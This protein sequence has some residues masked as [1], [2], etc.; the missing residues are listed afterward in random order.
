M[1]LPFVGEAI[2]ALKDDHISMLG[3]PTSPR[4]Q[5]CPIIS[6]YPSR[7]NTI[8]PMQKSIRFF[9][10]MLPA[11][12]ARVKPVSTIAKP[13]CIQNTKAAPIKYQNST[14][15]KSSPVSL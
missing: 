10:I 3:S 1:K 9:I 13:A 7:E 6:E 2:N 12:F 5:S 4:R 8:V 11:F 14:V 15:I